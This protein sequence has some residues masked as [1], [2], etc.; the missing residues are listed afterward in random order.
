MRPTRWPSGTGS[1]GRRGTI[2]A[3]ESRSLP[4]Q[5]LDVDRRVDA[6]ECPRRTRRDAGGPMRAC[7]HAAELG[8][9]VALDRLALVFGCLPKLQAVQQRRWPRVDLNNVIGAVRGTLAAPNAFLLINVDLT[10][11]PAGQGVRRTFSHALGVLTVAARRRD[12]HRGKGGAGGTVEARDTA[13]RRGAC[14][15]AIVAPHA[16]GL[17]DKQEVRGFPGTGLPQE[18]DNT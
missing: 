5:L 7:T 10:S 17:V 18:I 1:A 4:H 2:A 8:T 9:E 12:V 13:V 16:Q 3:D 14:L 15:L 11:A 6:Y